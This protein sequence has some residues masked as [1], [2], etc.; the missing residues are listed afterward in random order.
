[1]KADLFFLGLVLVA[2]VVFA[3]F[4]GRATVELLEGVTP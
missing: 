2:V 1:M 3:A 4:V